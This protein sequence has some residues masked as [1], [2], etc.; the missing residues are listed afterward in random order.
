M[1][2]T[3]TRTIASDPV[4]RQAVRPH[5]FTPAA[6]A[7]AFIESPEEPTQRYRL[8]R[9]VR[10]RHWAQPI[11]AVVGECPAVVPAEAG[12]AGSIRLAGARAVR[13]TSI[14]CKTRVVRCLYAYLVSEPS[15][16]PAA[17]PGVEDLLS[18]SL[19]PPQFRFETMRG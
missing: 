18:A 15:S 19:D 2:S 9:S 1:R 4:R 7:S 5:R 17:T 6:H 10:V 14:G 13:A 11:L 12:G 3:T 16:S 8:N